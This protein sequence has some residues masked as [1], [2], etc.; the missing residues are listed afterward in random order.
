MRTLSFPPEGSPFS[1]KTSIDSQITKSDATN[2]TIFIYNTRIMNT[3]E[4]AQTSTPCRWGR[5][6]TNSTST[7]YL[8]RSCPN[9]Q[10]DSMPIQPRRRGSAEAL[11]TERT[12]RTEDNKT[13]HS[14]SP[15][16]INSNPIPFSERNRRPKYHERWSFPTIKNNNNNNDTTQSL[17]WTLHSKTTNINNTNAERHEKENNTVVARTASERIPSPRK[18]SPLSKRQQ[19][20]RGRQSHRRSNLLKLCWSKLNLLETIDETDDS[21]DSSVPTCTCTTPLPS[22][23]PSLPFS[24]HKCDDSVVLTPRARRLSPPNVVVAKLA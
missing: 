4:E 20:N 13:L 12:K 3:Q 22:L 19:P 11:T 21:S 5:I 17:D 7:S 2:S 10:S 15:H 14:S 8:P 1:H 6:H 16:I 24:V 9:T 23:L 18:D